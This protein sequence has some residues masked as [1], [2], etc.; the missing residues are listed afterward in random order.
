MKNNDD[1]NSDAAL[2]L[3]ELILTILCIWAFYASGHEGLCW[4][5]IW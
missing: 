1:G 3:I 5:C 4:L 2:F